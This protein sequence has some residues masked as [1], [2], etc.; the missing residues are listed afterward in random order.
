MRVWPRWAG[1]KA[2]WPWQARS[3][4]AWQGGWCSG[5]RLLCIYLAGAVWG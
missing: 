2:A 4:G 5:A 3:G 1:D